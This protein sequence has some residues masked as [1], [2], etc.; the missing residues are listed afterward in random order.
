MFSHR[1]SPR[2]AV[3]GQCAASRLTAGAAAGG[4]AASYVEAVLESIVEGTAARST[5]EPAP[6]G[7]ADGRARACV[8][9]AAPVLLVSV[10]IITWA[11]GLEF[12]DIRIM[13]AA[14][15]RGGGA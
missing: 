1:P 12:A 10:L 15:G 13:W 7:A 5:S 4:S 14:D 8:E 2:G 3:W 9:V 11:M 6:G